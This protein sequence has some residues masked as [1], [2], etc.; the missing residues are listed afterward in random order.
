M[1][2]L[3]ERLKVHCRNCEYKHIPRSLTARYNDGDAKR[4]QLWE[5]R[6][7]GHIWSDT[8]FKKASE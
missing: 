8:A 3:M 2:R 6:D 5:C 1:G 7:C 4:I